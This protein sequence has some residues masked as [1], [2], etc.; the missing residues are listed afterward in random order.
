MDNKIIVSVHQPN[1]MPWL[2]FFDKM[3]KSDVFVIYDT[4]QIPN[5]KSS[6]TNRAKLVLNGQLKWG[7]TIPISK[8]KN[9]LLSIKD[10]EIIN[11]DFF[12]K[13]FLK[14]I[15]LYYKKAPFYNEVIDFLEMMILYD[16]NSLF[17]YN[18]HA[19]KLISDKIGFKRKKII[20][21]SELGFSFEEDKDLNLRIIEIVKKVGGQIYLS[22]NG[23]IDYMNNDL[24]EKNNILLN[25]QNYIHPKYKQFNSPEFHAGVSIIDALMNLGFTGVSNLYNIK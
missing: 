15:S 2:G 4:G 20:L 24:F 5:K 23:S 9:G 3:F 8:R 18:L 11:G 16:S 13:K 19:I 6:Y 17:S 14:T 7:N 22:G 25:F 1:F 10:V 21:S 12:K